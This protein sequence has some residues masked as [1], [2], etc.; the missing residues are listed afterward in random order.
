[1]IGKA[2]DCGDFNEF[3][4]FVTPDAQRFGKVRAVD[5]GDLDMSITI[6]IGGT[7][8]ASQRLRVPIW[9]VAAIF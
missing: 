3:T 9:G 6:Q 2:R 5:I 1:M 7:D 4:V 8:G